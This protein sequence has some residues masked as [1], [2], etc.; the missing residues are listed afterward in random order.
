MVKIG[1][2]VKTL[3]LFFILSVFY[4]VFPQFD[5]SALAVSRL[6]LVIITV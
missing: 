2:S 6:C 5:W 4:F 1:K 3:L